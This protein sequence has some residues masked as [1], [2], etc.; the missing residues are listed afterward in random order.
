MQPPQLK[1]LNDAVDTAAAA[2]LGAPSHPDLAV[3]LV[4]VLLR[5]DS[6]VL[7]LGEALRR[8][9]LSALR[10]GSKSLASLSE[11]L[12][13]AILMERPLSEIS[14]AAADL[15]TAVR[16]LSS[17]AMKSRLDQN[18]KV[19]VRMVVDATQ[20]LHSQLQRLG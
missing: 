1:P 13:L 15:W 11:A 18:S 12:K 3:R 17:L 10:D 2:S 5:L 20:S 7:A 19:L 9:K 4:D 14:N 16:Q 8:S 6:N